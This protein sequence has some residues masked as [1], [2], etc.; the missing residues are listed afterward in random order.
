MAANPREELLAKIS[1]LS[2]AEIKTILNYI[3][4]V[5]PDEGVNPANTLLEGYDETADPSVG[6]FDGPEDL[7]EQVENILQQGFGQPTHESEQTSS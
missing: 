1:Q 3:R 6:F 2:D 4:V 7:S 5:H